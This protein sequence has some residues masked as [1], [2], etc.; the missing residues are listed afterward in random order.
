MRFLVL[1]AQAAAKVIATY[2]G[3]ARGS[4]AT[5]GHNPGADG[6][7]PQDIHRP[8]GTYL[9]SG[10]ILL[11][12]RQ[13]LGAGAPEHAG[14]EDPYLYLGGIRGIAHCIFPVKQGSTRFTST[15]RRLP[16]CKWRS[17][18]ANL[19]INAGPDINLDVV[20][21][22]GGNGIATSYV[23]AGI[24]PEN[25]GAIHVDYTSEVSLLNAVE[26]LPSDS[27]K[28]MPVRITASPSQ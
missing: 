11:R 19:S 3:V 12:R 13:H 21:N 9:E 1:R 8:F 6:N 20:D 17:R 2:P 25:N 23:L 15:L 24:R 4:A 27:D 10:P 7:R 5:Q 14:T 26:I 22:A 28:L 18:L 16:N